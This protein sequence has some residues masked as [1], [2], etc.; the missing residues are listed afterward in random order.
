MITAGQIRAARGMLNISQL[1]LAVDAGLNIATI[2]KIE[3]DEK[4]FENASMATIK[5]IKSALESRGI[6]FIIPKT[7]GKTVITSIKH[8]TTVE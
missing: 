2:S 6:V 7:D 1:E 8:V 5:K 3:N 4:A